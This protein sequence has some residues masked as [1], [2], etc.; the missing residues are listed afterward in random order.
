[1]KCT[2]PYLTNGLVIPLS[3]MDQKTF[4]TVNGQA[5]WAGTKFINSDYACLRYHIYIEQIFIHKTMD[6]LGD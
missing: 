3:N 5:F 4:F 2:S 6:A 1:M